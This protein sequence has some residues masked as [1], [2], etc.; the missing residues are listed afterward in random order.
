MSR[1]K[2]NKCQATKLCVARK[3]RHSIGHPSFGR[4]LQVCVFKHSLYPCPGHSGTSNFYFKL[5]STTNTPTATIILSIAYM[6][7]LRLGAVSL[8]K[9]H[10]GTLIYTACL[11]LACNI[12]DDAPY[13]TDSWATL[14]GH[15][16]QLINR[17]ARTIA[18]CLD[19]RLQVA[20]EV[21]A[22]F[23]SFVMS[24]FSHNSPP[25]PTSRLPHPAPWH[26][27]HPLS[28]FC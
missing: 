13:D 7:K 15:S 2:N 23:E 28:K 20:P 4:F 21:H 16:A 27:F 11:M 3:A 14:S 18:L 22:K 19:Y 10:P 9:E 8:L 17:V 26:T 24:Y 6:T 12:L 25:F 1:I 5:L